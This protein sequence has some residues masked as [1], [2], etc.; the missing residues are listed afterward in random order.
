MTETKASMVRK[1]RRE[2]KAL[3]YA[4]ERVLRAAADLPFFT[5]E[6]ITRLLGAHG[7][8]GSYFRGL[9]KKLCGGADGKN[10][11]YLYRFGMPQAPG[12]VRRLYTLTRRGAGL[13]RKLGVEANFWYRPWK[14]SHYSFS[15]LQHHH[16]TVQVLV[17]LS[18]FVRQNPTYQV[19][20]LRHGFAIARQPPRLTLCVDEQETTVEVIPDAWVHIERSAGTPPNIHGFALWIEIDRGT[21]T[22]SKFKNLVLNRVNLVRSKAY[23]TFFGTPALLCCYLTVGATMD[24]RLTRLQRIREWTAEVLAEQ[25]LDPWGA[26]FRFSTIDECL[27]DTLMIFTDPVWYCVDSDTPVPLFTPPQDKEEARGNNQTTDLS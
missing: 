1:A 7:S 25:E 3:S 5:A 8:Q 12:N 11:A 4:E 2:P 24:Y 21:E 16:S 27:Y 9:L 22:K 10:T 26:I 15:F 23:E 13:L 18:C 19:V 14:A 20:E 6:D 17:A